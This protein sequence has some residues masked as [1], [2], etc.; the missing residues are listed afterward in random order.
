MVTEE[1]LKN[2]IKE[3]EQTH[4]YHGY[5]TNNYN[6]DISRRWKDE[7]ARQ[8]QKWQ[9]INDNNDVIALINRYDNTVASFEKATHMFYEDGFDMALALYDVL[10]GLRKM[11]QFIEPKRWNT[12][13]FTPISEE[14]ADALFARL[15]GIAIR[16]SDVNL[17]RAMSD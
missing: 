6:K 5:L 9:A 4:N 16:M 10:Q 12:T 8:N 1:Y 14:E 11:A 15:D 2:K 17:R 7:Q 3:F 13:K